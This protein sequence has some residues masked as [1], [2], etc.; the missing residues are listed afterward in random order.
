[1]RIW[2]DTSYHRKQVLDDCSD[3]DQPGDAPTHIPWPPAISNIELVKMLTL[4]LAQSLYIQEISDNRWLVCNPS[5]SGQIAVLD[6]QAMSLL[7]LFRIPVTLAQIAAQ[8]QLEDLEAASLF[9]HLGFLHDMNNHSPPPQQEEIQTLTAWLH[10]TNEC[11][12]RC[13][14]CYLQK[15]HENM[16][17]FIGQRSVDAIFRSAQKHNINNVRLKYAGG[18]ASLHMMSVMALHDYASQQ[19]TK[20]GIT[21]SAVILSNGVALSQR[22]IEYLKIRR[23]AITI[24]LD[25]LGVYQDNQRPLLGG[26]GSSKYVQRTIERL[27]VNNMKP[28]LSVTVSQRNLSGLPALMHYILQHDLPFSLNYYRENSFSTSLADLRIINEQIITVMRSTFELIENN[29]PERC[30]LSSLLD[31]TDAAANHL[32][33]CG[34]GQNYMV[35]NQDGGVA[36]CQMD[37]RRTVATIDSDDPLHFIRKD[38]YGV[39]GLNVEEK[40]GCR[41]CVWRYWCTGGCPM[42]TYRSTGRYDVKSPY[43]NIYK[44]LFPDVLRLE[45]LRLLHYIPEFDFSVD[46]VK[47]TV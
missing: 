1:M 35:I 34:V 24:S 43:C 26:Q 31:K 5:Q 41:T 39:Q 23:I 2:L 40:E 20:Y 12:M 6:T 27:L 15:T 46:K 45:A 4:Q 32:H 30:L 47:T 18:E 13:H 44:A 9:Y 7:T 11:N 25:G 33:T 37:M 8:E 38:R 17:D 21:L 16:S 19:A 29:L 28:S 42:L 22:T 36:K 10:V 3:C 14:Y